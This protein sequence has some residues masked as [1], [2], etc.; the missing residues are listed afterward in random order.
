MKILICNE[1]FLFRFGVDRVLIIL[2][3]G[4]NDLGH[5]IFIM[6]NRFDREIVE[7]FASKIIKVPSEVEYINQNEYVLA[8]LEH[9]WDQH[10]SHGGAPDIVLVGGWPFFLAIPF[11]REKGCKVV[12]SDHGVV[13]LD[14]YSGH[15][16][17]VLEKLKKFRKQNLKYSSM[18]IG[19]SQFIVRS[20]SY[21][22]SNNTTKVHYILNGA[23]HMDMKIWS[24]KKIDLKVP[25]HYSKKEIDI[26]K[27][28][29]TKIILL[30]GRWEP[31]C[32]KNSE[33]AFDILAKILSV[34][35]NCALL[36]LADPSELKIPQN[37]QD[38]I[39][40]IGFPDDDALANIMK[41]VDLGLSVSL[42]EGF[43][44]P[45]AE[46]Q[47]RGKP[48]LAFNIGAH[49]E[50][51]LHP[52]YLCQDRNEMV[53]KACEILGGQGLDSEIKKDSLEKFRN[54]FR[55]N[56]VISDYN[57]LFEKLIQE[58]VDE[59]YD[60][61]SLIV[62]VTN[63]SRDPANSG[64]IR[65]T[66]RLSREFQRYLDPIFVVWDS[67]TSCYVLPTKQEAHQLSQFN[68]PV[69]TDERR[70]SPNDYR[71]P[72]EE[73]LCDIND[74]NIWLIFPETLSEK[75]GRIARRFARTY[76]IKLA[77]IFH[78]S[79]PILFPELCKDVATRDNHS[80]YMIGLAECDVVIPNS[81][82]SA[83]CLKKFWKDNKIKGCTISPDPLPGEFGGFERIQKLREPS[84]NEINILCVSTLEPR[85]NHKKLVEA[86]L[87]MQEGH[88][89]LDWS[90]TL[91]GN[92]YT[93]AFEIADFIEEISAKNPR[94]KW[95]GIVDDAKLHKLYEDATFTVYPSFIEG[96]GMPI[97]ESLWHG[98]PC[99][100]H[101]EGVMAELAAEGGCL[102]TNVLDENILSESIYKLCSDRSLLSK[103]S[104]EA[105]GRKIK[106][107]ADYALEFISILESQDIRGYS[108]KRN[109][110]PEDNRDWQEILYPE[111]LCEHWQM[112]HSER[113]AITALLSR[114][115]PRCSIEIGT[116]RGGSLSL[117]SQYSEIVFSID[118][119]PSLPEKF[120]HLKNVCFLTGPSSEILPILL[121][122]LDNENFP[123]DF[124]LI[125]GDHSAE[126][127]KY[128]IECLLSYIP[129][130]PLLVMMHDSFNPECRRGMLEA[131]WQ[132]SLYVDWVDLDFVPG[133]IIEHNGPTKGEMW[134]GLALA[135]FKP[136]IRKR[137]INFNLSANMMHEIIKKNR[138][139]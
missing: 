139:S 15:H 4:L 12:F 118:I 53:S 54:Y 71:I 105:I 16:L 22:D 95:L 61:L 137:A 87:L 21:P 115:K 13:P 91:V 17:S 27:T 41:K 135:Y 35:P 107:W 84:Q 40:P 83:D 66:R 134:G 43:N 73:Y 97:L 90:L 131:K 129:N 57:E 55:W 24:S 2:G 31:G 80:Q 112:N 116:Y 42:W 104:R 37:L 119:D 75:Y 86:C 5:D 56:R 67:G 32:Y 81:N 79:I 64:V 25:T 101:Q 108:A 51:I 76:G 98:R 46:M 93:G 39:I 132:S 99:I 96:F 114:H 103:L 70:M 102:T 44:L 36:I 63:A 18:I 9:T 38:A 82:F 125:D 23:D 59:G 120:G 117:I 30:L 60:R 123:V 89:E 62:D 14:G 109:A 29:R 52:W 106:T 78:D 28:E 72:L 136:S 113:L 45:I 33:A 88:P 8:W 47:W 48:V 7:P 19:V 77:A 138:Q 69:L 3:K 121:N 26:L 130:R 20:Q 92:R 50:V 127:I 1:R 65:V 49:S 74:D 6:G 111:C 124:I 94:I 133:R 128:D 10:F 100:C 126:G 34:F 58:P 122:E 11:F 68:G 110:I 85:K